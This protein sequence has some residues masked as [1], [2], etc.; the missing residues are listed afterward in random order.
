[1][2]KIKIQSIV[3]KDLK[4]LQKLCKSALIGKIKDADITND[5]DSTLWIGDI[6]DQIRIYQLIIKN[7]WG[8]AYNEYCDLDTASRDQIN[9]DVAEFLID[10]NEI[11]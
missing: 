3:K 7:K 4:H 9:D 1:M 8:K 5:R 10:F 11:K 6:S 2:T